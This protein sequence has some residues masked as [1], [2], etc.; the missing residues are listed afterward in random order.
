MTNANVKLSELDPSLLPSEISEE[1]PSYLR[2]PKRRQDLEQIATENMTILQRL[3]DKAPVY[4]RAQ[5]LEEREQNLNYLFNIAMYPQTYQRILKELG[6]DPMKRAIAW[7]KIEQLQVQI[8]SRSKNFESVG[9]VE[10]CVD[11]K[12][13]SGSKSATVSSLGSGCGGGRR[14][15]SGR[16]SQTAKVGASRSVS[17]RESVKSGMS[18]VRVK[19]SKLASRASETATAYGLNLNGK[20]VGLINDESSPAVPKLPVVG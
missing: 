17:G 10:N 4:S 13:K 14:S 11:R 8:N 18:S 7:A 1:Y 9:K 15:G 2:N 20:K 12:L 3:E 6:A 5:A 19:S 16:R